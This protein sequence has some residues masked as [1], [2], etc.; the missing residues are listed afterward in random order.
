MTEKISRECKI[1]REALQSHIDASEPLPAHLLDHLDT[2]SACRSFGE[3][4]L[5]LPE[6]LRSALDSAIE[7]Q[8]PPDFGFLEQGQNSESRQKIK[9]KPVVWAAAAMVFALVSILGYFGYTSYRSHSFIRED[10][11]IFVQGILEQSLFD[12]GLQE[13]RYV[14][15]GSSSKASTWFQESELSSELLGELPFSF[16]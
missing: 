11:H 8:G 3:T 2:C 16:D 7:I 4:L 12:A 15:N 10:N 14:L 5:A 1:V 6:R 13:S 9:R